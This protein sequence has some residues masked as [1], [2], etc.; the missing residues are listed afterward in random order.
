MGTV[1]TELGFVAACIQSI[2]SHTWEIASIRG[3]S[4]LGALRTPIVG[5]LGRLAARMTTTFPSEA[6]ELK[7]S[8]I[9]QPPPPITQTARTTKGG[10]R[11][12][13]THTS[14]AKKQKHRTNA[15]VWLLRVRLCTGTTLCMCAKKKK[16]TS[17]PPLIQTNK[18]TTSTNERGRGR[19]KKTQYIHELVGRR[20]KAD[21]DQN[22]QQKEVKEGRGEVGGRW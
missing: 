15:C 3:G 6:L 12:S 7:R 14:F 18:R 13:L 4:A 2:V 9:P 11:T 16:P 21:R 22:A 20:R 8:R 5:C 17:Q 10:G 19:K 1:R